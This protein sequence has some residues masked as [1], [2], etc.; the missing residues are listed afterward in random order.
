MTAEISDTG[1]RP[2]YGAWSLNIRLGAFR[3]KRRKLKSHSSHHVHVARDLG[4]VLHLQLPTAFQ[5]VNSDTVS[6]M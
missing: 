1:I 3:P 5:R 2:I 6:T 4:Q